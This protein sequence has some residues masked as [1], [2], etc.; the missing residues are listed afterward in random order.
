MFYYR[1]P[2]YQLIKP[3]EYALM[4]H[5]NQQEC[6]I[7]THTCQVILDISGSP[8]IFN[9]ASGNIQGNLDRYV[10]PGM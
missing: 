10:I 2:Q 3:E 9:W 7:Q 8:L 5:T 4:Y 6:T 1:M